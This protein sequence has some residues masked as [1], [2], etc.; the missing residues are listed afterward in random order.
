MRK[1]DLTPR[2]SLQAMYTRR[3]QNR[4][5]STVRQIVEKTG[6]Y[7][8]KDIFSRSH[9]IERAETWNDEHKVVTITA[10][11]ADSSGRRDSFSVDLVTMRIC[12]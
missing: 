6:G 12:G 9:H 8:E 1:N 7:R 5:F 10:C 4:L 3:A 11:N 2:Q